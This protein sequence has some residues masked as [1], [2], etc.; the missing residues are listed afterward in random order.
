MDFVCRMKEHMPRSEFIERTIKAIGTQFSVM[1]VSKES[2]DV[3]SDSEY[4]HS[5]RLL[6]EKEILE[7]SVLQT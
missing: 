7:A 1:P 5:T 3:P 2:I 4:V 6:T